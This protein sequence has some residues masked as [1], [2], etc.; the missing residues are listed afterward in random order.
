[1]EALGDKDDMPLTV[2]P[3]GRESQI[4]TM[5]SEEFADLLL[6]PLQDDRWIRHAE[7]VRMDNFVD[8]ENG[9]RVKEEILREYIVEKQR[10]GTY[11]PDPILEGMLYQEQFMAAYRKESHSADASAARSYREKLMGEHRRA[12]AIKSVS[13]AKEQHEEKVGDPGETNAAD[14][15]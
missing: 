3:A 14:A 7:I 13:E 5:P 10:Q 15:M 12:R 6:Q 4:L 2:I 8:T 11:H 9:Q 1:M